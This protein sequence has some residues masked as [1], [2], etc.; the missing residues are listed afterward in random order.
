LVSST[1]NI[2]FGRASATV[3]SIS[4]APSF[5]AKLLPQFSAFEPHLGRGR[6]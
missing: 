1:R 5:F 6:V 4:I 2:A 3:P